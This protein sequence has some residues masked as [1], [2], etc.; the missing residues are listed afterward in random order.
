MVT[1]PRVFAPPTP[2]TAGL[3][4]VE[5]LLQSP[6][7]NTLGEGPM[8]RLHLDRTIRS[9]RAAGNLVHDAHIAALLIEHGVTEVLTADRDFSRFPGLR[10]RDPF[11]S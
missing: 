11:T 5:S 9:S 2:V 4:D 8:H 1:H 6:S 3:D 10:M 7:V